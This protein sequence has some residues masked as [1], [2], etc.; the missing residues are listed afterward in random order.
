MSLDRNRG[1]LGQRTTA[2]LALVAVTLSV[3]TSAQAHNYPDPGSHRWQLYN[4]E[5][6]NYSV[7][8]DAMTTTSTRLKVGERELSSVPEETTKVTTEERRND[9]AIVE[10]YEYPGKATDPVRTDREGPRT[11]FS[12]ISG[13]IQKF[14]SRQR[15]DHYRVTRTI[16]PF[17]LYDVTRWERRYHKVFEVTY[18]VTDNLTWTDPRTGEVLSQA[19]PSYDVTASEP[20]TTAWENKSSEVLTKVD[21]DPPVD[22]DTYLGSRN[23][24]TLIYTRALTAL[25]A[26]GAGSKAK[27]GANAFAGDRSRSVGQAKVASGREARTMLGQTT[28]AAR[29]QATT[30]NVSGQSARAISWPGAFVGKFLSFGNGANDKVQV[31]DNG[32]LKKGNQRF[33][34][35]DVSVVGGVLQVR[36]SNNGQ[37]VT[38]SPRGNG[39]D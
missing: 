31:L 11:T 1:H 19:A 18:R 35:L 8:E 9:A 21:R 4:Q 28:V 2:L 13:R 39:N 5:S 3:G 22:V 32:Q 24:D 12:T 10:V 37:I 16:Q 25:T 29:A 33:N 36:F 15:M 20:R 38:A 6:V 7:C 17:K 26:G 14:Y 23:I 34:A 27:V 30:V